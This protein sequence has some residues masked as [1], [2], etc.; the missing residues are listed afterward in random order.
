M[1]SDDKNKENVIDKCIED[2]YDKI[3]ETGMT[4]KCVV[5][6]K[7]E[8]VIDSDQA[9]NN[10]DISTPHPESHN[11]IWLIVFLLV[12]VT[13]GVVAYISVDEGI[14]QE[15]PMGEEF[16]VEDSAEEVPRDNELKEEEPCQEA[17]SDETT[18]GNDYVQWKSI[19]V[20]Q[21]PIECDD[22][23]ST[24]AMAP[25]TVEQPKVEVPNGETQLSQQPESKTSSLTTPSST[26]QKSY[27][28]IEIDVETPYGDKYHKE[29]KG[30][31]SDEEWVNVIKS[32]NIT[33]QKAY[34]TI[35]LNT[36]NS[37]GA[38]RHSELKG[39]YT[40][41]EWKDIMLLDTWSLFNK[42]NS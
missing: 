28:S 11:I 39:Y 26:S 15:E 3:I 10:T 31:Y 40:K 42:K 2:A 5:V 30:F 9:T 32:I 14:K 7:G 33:S 36:E 34:Y 19:P 4:D 21:E 6:D 41:D 16:E 20:A 13:V 8:K 24:N 22:R 23:K 35:K 12:L 1:E 18:R 37:Q 25:F 29:I 17:H 38:E 27:Y